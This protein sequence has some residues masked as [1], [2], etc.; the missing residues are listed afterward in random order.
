VQLDLDDDETRAFL[1]LLVEAIEADR[2][3][4]SCRRRR[5]FV[6][7]RKIRRPPAVAA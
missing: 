6:T 7:G 5:R 1:N 3:P 2:Y 4:L